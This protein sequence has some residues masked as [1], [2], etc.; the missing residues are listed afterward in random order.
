[1][2][3]AEK[4]EMSGLVNWMIQFYQF[5]WQS[6]TPPTLDEGASTPTK[7]RLDGR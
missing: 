2:L 1:M 5:R 4:T 6:E 7:R 3:E